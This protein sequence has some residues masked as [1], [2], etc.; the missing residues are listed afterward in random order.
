MS[1]SRTLLKQNRSV[2]GIVRDILQACVDAGING[3]LVSKI[4]QRANLSY[5][6]ATDNCQKLPDLSWKYVLVLCYLFAMF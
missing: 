1:M 5:G 3:I 4:S 6:K 2:L